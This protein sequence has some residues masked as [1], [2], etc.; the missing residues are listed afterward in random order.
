MLVPGCIKHE[1]LMMMDDAIF[2]VVECMGTLYKCI[3]NVLS[4]KRFRNGHEITTFADGG[5][6]GK[7]EE[8][9]QFNWFSK[10]GYEMYLK[11]RST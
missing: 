6:D 1:R 8:I 3:K 2:E 10:E 7:L 11:G 9:L 5:C 4:A